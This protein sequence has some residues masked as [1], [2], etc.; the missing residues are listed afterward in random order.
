[1]GAQPATV[2]F[3]KAIDGL[4]SFG[5]PLHDKAS[6][7]VIDNFRDRAGPGYLALA[8]DDSTSLLG[9]VVAI[10]LRQFKLDDSRRC[11]SAGREPHRGRKAAGLCRSL[12]PS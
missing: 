10:P 8:L 9:Q 4:D 5:F 12:K 11:R 1:M 6:Y 7:F 3:T 2:K